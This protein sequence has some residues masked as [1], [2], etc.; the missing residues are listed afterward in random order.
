MGLTRHPERYIRRVSQGSGSHRSLNRSVSP[1]YTTRE[2]Q[3]RIFS[4]FLLMVTGEVCVFSQCTP[5]TSASFDQK[6]GDG[7]ERSMVAFYFSRT[8][9]KFFAY[10]LPY[11]IHYEI[12]GYEK[13]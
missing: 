5:I 9:K 12:R 8:Y 6:S 2:N 11:L 7:G 3:A 13:Y 1:G 4:K 10:E